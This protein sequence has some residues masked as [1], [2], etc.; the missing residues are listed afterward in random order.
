M[1]NDFLQAF[2]KYTDYELD[3]IVDYI[4]HSNKSITDVQ[5]QFEERLTTQ[6]S[7]QFIINVTAEHR[8]DY[9]KFNQIFP[10]FFRMST[11]IG[12]YSYFENKLSR[13]CEHIHEKKNY[14]LKASDLSGDNLIERA[15]RYFKLVVDVE[16]DDLNTEWTKITDYQKI[17]NRLV[18]NGSNII[19]EKDK[20]VEQQK[21]YRIIKKYPLLEVT[22]YGIIIIS[23]DDFLI[24]FVNLQKD[25]LAKLIDKLD[26]KFRE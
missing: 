22:P 8:D 25:Y 16:L 17:R 15:R 18:H 1:T 14:R 11:F 19:A 21:L 23:S 7:D 26:P 2:K 20:P 6:E 10:N 9:S 4:R 3:A 12:Q 13:L 24:D 5:K